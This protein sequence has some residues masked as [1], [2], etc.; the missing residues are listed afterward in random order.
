M[1]EDG[2]CNGSGPQ[3]YRKIDI[4][5]HIIPR[6]WPNWN[7]KFGYT[8]WLRIEHDSDDPGKAT[9][10]NGDGAFFRTIESNCWCCE[11]RKEECDGAGVDVQVLS[12]VPGIGFNY[13]ARGEDALHVARF[14]NDDLAR[15]V[16]EAPD[17]FMALG[18]VPMQS[19][20]LAVQE[21]R[22]CI[23]ELGMPGVQIGTHVNDWNLDDPALD[24]FWNE[25]SVLSASIFVHPWD[26]RTGP[27]Y[28]RHWF[29][30]LLDMPH[31]TSMAVGS[32]LMGGVLDRWPGLQVCFA[33]GGGSIAQLM[34][35]IEHGFYAR[36]DLCQTATK[37]SPAEGL[38]RIWVDSLVHDPD[39]L[40]LLLAKLGPERILLGS[41]YPFPLGEVP[42]PGELIETG[43]FSDDPAENERI[44]RAML[45]GNAENF[46]NLH[47]TRK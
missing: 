3:H 6:E 10:V 43:H 15:N 26:M 7:E 19:P 8:G 36:P 14:I 35:R 42:R 9:L 4:H 18:T 33:H 37:M 23:L 41:D 17:R 12:T 2:Q 5:T 45:S 47:K 28:E 38:K 25:A 39:V 40:R 1:I 16:R 31:E 44:R 22:R 13:W 46:L 11:R 24:S 27:R 32:M 30:W 21:L 20:D 29:P 34:G